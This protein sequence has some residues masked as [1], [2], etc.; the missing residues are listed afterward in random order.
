MA[1]S[2]DGSIEPGV[3]ATGALQR[4]GASTV[5]QHGWLLDTNKV[6]IAHLHNF[7]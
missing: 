1:L 3:G 2:D 4:F 7:F 6:G 5:A